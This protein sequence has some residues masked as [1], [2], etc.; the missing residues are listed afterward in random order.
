[1]QHRSGVVGERCFER[2]ELVVRDMPE[3]RRQRPNVLPVT[4]VPGCRQGAKR[5]AMVATRGRDNVG[6]PGAHA[7]KF[8]GAFNGLGP[9]VAEEEALQ[10]RWGNRGEL[11]EQRRAA[12]IVEQLWAGD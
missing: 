4:W 9:G 7:G 5:A 10:P 11:L 3:A 12:V 1:Q 6:F 8:N 2:I